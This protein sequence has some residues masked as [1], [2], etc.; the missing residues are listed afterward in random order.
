MKPDGKEIVII[1]RLTNKKKEDYYGCKLKARAQR[2][3]FGKSY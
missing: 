1:R 2:R 3:T